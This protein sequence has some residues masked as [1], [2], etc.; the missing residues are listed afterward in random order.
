MSFEK[1]KHLLEDKI[2]KINNIPTKKEVLKVIMKTS[3]DIINE[4]YI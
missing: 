2:N 3:N 1:S 4:L